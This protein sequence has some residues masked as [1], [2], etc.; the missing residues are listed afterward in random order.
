[1]FGRK[2]TADISEDE[3]RRW[4][5]AQRPK[6]DWF[7]RRSEMEQE[8]MARLGDD[9]TQD[10]CV[11]I[12]YAVKDPE[13]A[14]AGRD[15]ATNPESESI[16]AQR[17]AADM[18][19]AK[20]AGDRPGPIA[21]EAPLTMGGFGARK[22]RTEIRERTENGVTTFLGREPDPKPEEE[23]SAEAEVKEDAAG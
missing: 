6:W 13:I 8:G 2:K 10:F 23:P 16:L 7:F 21:D 4:L 1:M 11:G 15:A 3:Y 20:M 19:A 5:R 18:I 22:I 17:I 14:D 12:G 9:Y